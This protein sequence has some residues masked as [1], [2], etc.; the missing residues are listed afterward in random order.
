M[1]ADIDLLDLIFRISTAIGATIAFFVGFRQ[2]RRG[3]NWR[4]ARII[5]SLI[6]SFEKDDEIQMACT[7]LD[8][9]ERK[10]A[11]KGGKA[12]QFKN[13]MLVAALRITEMDIISYEQSNRIEKSDTFTEEEG[14]IRDGFA[15]F[16]DFFHKLT[17]LQRRG[18]LSFSDY[19]YF[20]YYLELLNNVGVYKK[21]SRLQE[22]FKNYIENYGFVEVKELLEQYRKLPQEVRDKYTLPILR[23]RRLAKTEHS[24]AA[25]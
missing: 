5:T 7:M 9:D 16:F 20:Y 17:V 4:K 19:E 21:N 24:E 11:I 22:V 25:R 23:R 6:D 3:Q 1:S 14:I 13:E 18:L 10:I 15:A 8:W 12:I 2:Y